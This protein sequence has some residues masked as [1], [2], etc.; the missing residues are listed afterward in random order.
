MSMR[1][2][3]NELG[4]LLE[5][6]RWNE[7]AILRL[8]DGREIRGYKLVDGVVFSHRNPLEAI[9]LGDIETILIEDRLEGPE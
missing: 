7:D 9:Y 6:L 5:E 2:D 4:R 8:K 3:P 1:P